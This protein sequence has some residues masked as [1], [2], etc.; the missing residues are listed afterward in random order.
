MHTGDS[1]FCLDLEAIAIFLIPRFMRI[2]IIA[3]VCSPS[4]F[5][6]VFAFL[7]FFCLMDLFVISLLNPDFEVGS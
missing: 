6:L 7:S 5:L 4:L 3:L 1:E 2:S